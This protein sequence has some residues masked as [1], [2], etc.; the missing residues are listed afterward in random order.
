MPLHNRDDCL[1]HPF[2]PD[3]T[4][5]QDRE[6]NSTF[7][8]LCRCYICDRKASECPTWYL[9]KSAEECTI[10]NDI[11]TRDD[12]QSREQLANES[13]RSDTENPA[14]AFKKLHENQNENTCPFQ[15]HSQATNK[16]RRKR[17]WISMRNAKKQG[18]DT[19]T[20][21]EANL[22]NSEYQS[23]YVQK[24]VK[25]LEHSA[26][27]NLTK[28]SSNCAKMKTFIDHPKTCKVS[29]YRV[30]SKVV[31]VTITNLEMT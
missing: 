25:L 21:P 11:T 27:C 3:G 26:C 1:Q 24:H 14:A 12:D 29:C 4:T 2:V 15:N 19:S 13:I 16:G 9:G 8:E 28:C 23:H 7:C 5:P 6:A 10:K 30:L 22:T 17:T 31:A 20:V 18:R